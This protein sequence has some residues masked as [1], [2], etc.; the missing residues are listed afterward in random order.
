MGQTSGF[1]QA[2][3]DSSLQDPTTGE[4]TGWWDRNYIAQQFDWCLVRYSFCLYRC[5]TSMIRQSRTD[6]FC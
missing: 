2:Q 5:Q 6:Y 3:W 1:F 4:Y